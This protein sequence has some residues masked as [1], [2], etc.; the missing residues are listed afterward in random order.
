[1]SPKD[2]NMV[3]PGLLLDLT[4]LRMFSELYNKHHPLKDIKSKQREAIVKATCISLHQ[5]A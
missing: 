3:I 4:S 5:S 1:M 2:F